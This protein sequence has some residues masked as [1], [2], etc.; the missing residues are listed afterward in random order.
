MTRELVA[1]RARTGQQDP[2]MSDVW[3]GLRRKARDHARSPMQW[4]DSTNA[5]FSLT[6]EQTAEPWMRVHDDH[7]EWN[8]AKQREQPDSVMS[9]WKAMLA[10]RKNHLSSVSLFVL[11]LRDI[12]LLPLPLPLPLLFEGRKAE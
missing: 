10:F 3:D 4:D 9:F 8:V 12:L 11:S 2:D 1:R 7:K 5:G 6:N